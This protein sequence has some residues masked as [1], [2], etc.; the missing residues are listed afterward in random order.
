MAVR[1]TSLESRKGGGK[2]A[3]TDGTTEK[4]YKED[5]QARPAATV[6]QKRLFLEQ[7]TGKSLS[8]STVGRLLKRLGVSDKN[9]A[10]RRWSETNG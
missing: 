5:V 7:A 6:R 3:K 10:W 2:P 9:E 4:L 1:V 8:D